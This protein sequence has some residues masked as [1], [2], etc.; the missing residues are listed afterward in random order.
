ME[1]PNAD[2]SEWAMAFHTSTIVVQGIFE[3]AHRRILGQVMDFNCFT[4]IFNLV[5]AKQLHFGQSHP[6]IP[7]HLSFVATFARSIMMV[8]G[9]GRG[10]VR[11]RQIHPW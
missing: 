10:D 2:E 4:W 7:R 5:L 11:T 9:G 3:G 1:K 8:Q 6:P